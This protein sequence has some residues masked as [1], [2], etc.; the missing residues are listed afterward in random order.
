[1]MRPFG[2][3]FILVSFAL[4][5]AGLALSQQPVQPGGKGK[6]G[7]AVDPMSL[8]QNPQ[9]RAELKVSDQQLAKLPAASLKALAEVLDA[10]QL[11]RLRG[12]YLQQKGDAA[13]LEADVK[14]DLKISQDQAKAIQAALDEQ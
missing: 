3:L 14:T 5:A 12:I 13:F 8:F 11:Q 4:A 6:G 7:Q 2:R 9:V 10:K 1:L